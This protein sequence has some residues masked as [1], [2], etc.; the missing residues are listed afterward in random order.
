MNDGLP[1]R[2]SIRTSERKCFL[3]IDKNPVQ[4]VENSGKSDQLIT[5]GKEM[6]Y[7][8]G[9]PIEKSQDAKRRFHVK[10]SESLKGELVWFQKKILLVI[11]RQ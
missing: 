11:K 2:I 10:N 8:G 3:Q 9:L 5:K 4:I 6:L 7:I 1:H